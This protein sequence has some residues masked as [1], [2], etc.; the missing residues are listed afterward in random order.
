MEIFKCLY[1]FSFT[2][3]SL[4]TGLADFSF[5]CNVLLVSSKHSKPL[6]IKATLLSV[7]KTDFP[8]FLL[9]LLSTFIFFIKMSYPC[10]TYQSLLSWFLHSSLMLGS[11]MCNDRKKDISAYEI[12]GCD[13][14]WLCDLMLF[15]LLL[16]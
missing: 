16:T 6:P 12:Y 3:Y 14:L 4:I 11:R 15:K 1:L 7:E 10:P 8:N 13:S 5:L 2:S 9:F